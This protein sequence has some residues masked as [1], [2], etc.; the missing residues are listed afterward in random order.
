VATG[1]ANR[2]G[3]LGIMMGQQSIGEGVWSMGPEVA[4]NEN[5]DYKRFIIAIWKLTAGYVMLN[6]NFVTIARSFQN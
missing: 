6:R 2:T 5:S 4:L 1:A 3:A